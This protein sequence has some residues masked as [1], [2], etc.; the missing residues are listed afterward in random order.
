MKIR[1]S[2]SIARLEH[3]FKECSWQPLCNQRCIPPPIAQQGTVIRSLLCITG[4]VLTSAR[5]AVSHK[6]SC[7][8]AMHLKSQSA[9]L[10][11]RSLM[12]RASTSGAL[13][14]PRPAAK[15]QCARDLSG[16]KRSTIFLYDLLTCDAQNGTTVGN[17]DSNDRG[18]HL[19]ALCGE[20]YT[21]NRK[22][23]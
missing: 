14:V 4:G 22:H 11:M 5:R 17:A 1:G 7:A 8:S 21:F 2:Q 9:L 23:S 20:K 18:E 19:V 10:R 13:A 6:T 3:D 12:A 16:W 15:R